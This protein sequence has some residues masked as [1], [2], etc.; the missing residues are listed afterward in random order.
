[1]GTILT[2]GE[3]QQL[4]VRHKVERDGRIKDRIKAVLLRDDGLSYGELRGCCF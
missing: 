2:A 3:R 1:M 4:L